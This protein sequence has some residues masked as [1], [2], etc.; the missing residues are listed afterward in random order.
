MSKYVTIGSFDKLHE[1]VK[2]HTDIQQALE[3]LKTHPQYGG[4]VYADT[5]NLSNYTI[6]YIPSEVHPVGEYT[7]NVCIECMKN[8][9][10]RLSHYDDEKRAKTILFEELVRLGEFT[11][12]D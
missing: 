3:T 10:Y 9:F 4:F 11:I 2:K 6:T 7:L 12:Y 5:G 1:D 8:E